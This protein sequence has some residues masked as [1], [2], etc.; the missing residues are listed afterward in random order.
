MEVDAKVSGLKF[1]QKC[2]YY[3]SYEDMIWDQ[4]ISRSF[5]ALP[6]H[7]TNDVLE[8]FTTP[9]SLSGSSVLNKAYIVAE[10]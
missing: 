1:T 7:Q 9:L 6:L 5:N 10:Y 2:N 3:S 8:P 4:T